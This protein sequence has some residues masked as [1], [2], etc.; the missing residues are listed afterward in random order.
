MNHLKMLFF[1]SSILV[2]ASV[3]AESGG[4]R[5]IERMEGLRDKA[6]ATL[7][8]AEQAPEGERHVHMAEH[9]KMLGD[10]MSQL[11]NDHPD[12]SMSPQQHLTW[13]E[14]HDKIVDD[15]LRQ[16]QREHKLMLSENHQ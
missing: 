11:H 5:V 7:M 14:K 6:E 12:A 8:K 10:I 9:M 3:W 13:M 1:V 4:D 15:V 16:M 2:S